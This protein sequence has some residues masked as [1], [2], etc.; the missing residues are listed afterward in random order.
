M[1]AVAVI[2]AGSP[3]RRGLSRLSASPSKAAV[4][5]WGKPMLAYVVDA[6]LG[7]ARVERIV[8]V[9]APNLVSLGAGRARSVQWIPAGSSFGDCL[10]AGAEAAG[11]KPVLAVSSDLP[12]LT[13]EAVDAFLERC[14]EAGCDVACP[15]IPRASM[16]AALGAR[17]RAW[18]CVREGRFVPG[19]MAY[20]R[21]GLLSAGASFLLN[22]L[23]A[24]WGRPSLLAAAL[25]RR[26]SLPLGLG[27]LSLRDMQTRIEAMWGVRIA[28]VVISRAEIGFDVDTPF[29]LAVAL[30]LIARGLPLSLEVAAQ[31]PP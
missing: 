8:V 24:E 29:D 16:K 26:P 23:A 20:F 15:L 11:G 27:R 31:Q 30:G 28:P 6:L 14:A 17:R 7:A 4:R 21:P 22:R 5:L 10:R 13:P 18:L 19:N 25:G 9:G 1:S 3:C 12:L 2:L